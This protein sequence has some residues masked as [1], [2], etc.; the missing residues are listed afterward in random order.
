MFFWFIGTAVLAVGF[1]FRDQRFD[2]RLLIVGSVL[3]LADGFFGGTRALHS[4]TLTIT[5]LVVVMLGTIGRRQLRRTLLGL[6]IGMFLHLVFDGAWNN[7]EVFWWPFTGWD[8]GDDPLP[9][10]DR[11]LLTV[12]LELAGLA[13]CGWIWRVNHLSDRERRRA[14]LHD[15]RLSLPIFM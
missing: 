7:T 9:E 3:P 11:G 6:P 13:L 2:Y 15:G 1:V 8:F 10:L 5:V 14:F 4:I 12:V